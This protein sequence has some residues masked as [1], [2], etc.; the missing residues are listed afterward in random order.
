MNG[1]RINRLEFFTPDLVIGVNIHEL[2]TWIQ[3]VSA[4]GVCPEKN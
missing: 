3:V 2:K 4:T 1:D